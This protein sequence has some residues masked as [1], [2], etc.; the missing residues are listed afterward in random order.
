M[1]RKTMTLQSMKIHESRKDRIFKLDNVLGLDVL[2]VFESWALNLQPDH[3]DNPNKKQ[4]GLKPEVERRNRIVILTMRTG[5]Y[6][7][8]GDL[9]VDTSSHKTKYKTKAKDAQTVSTRCALL[10]PPNSETAL[11]FIEKQGHEGC[12]PRVMSSF[13]AHLKVLTESLPT[14]KGEPLKAVISVASVVSPQEWLASAEVESVTAVVNYYTSDIADAH[15]TKP[16]PMV[17]SSTL[18][19]AKGTRWLPRWVR[20]ILGN[21]D[22][23]AAADLG[24]PDDLDYDELVVT[25]NDGDRSKKM[26]I[27][28]KKTPSVRVMLNDDGESPLGMS[29][30]ISR[31]D[32]EASS[33]YKR[34]KVTHQMAWTRNLPVA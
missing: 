14:E 22:V 30:L 23:S 1:P 7:N 13:H 6:G 32:S 4:Y 28:K 20:D 16:V 8:P 21:D 25:L 17:F 33:Y 31:I 26:V 29:E 34:H 24:F 10:V 9:V 27:D 15:T 3:F 11:F 5:H 2:D 18:T 12:G 19:A